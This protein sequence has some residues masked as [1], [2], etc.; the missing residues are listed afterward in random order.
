[1]SAARLLLTLLTLALIGCAAT[2]V[3]KVAE[4]DRYH[5]TVTTADGW[6][7]AL[8][9]VPPAAGTEDR[10][11]HGVPLLMPHGTSVNRFNYMTPGSDLAGYLSS[12]GYDVWVPEHRGDR[13]SRGPTGRDLRSGGWSMDD[14][15]DQDMPAV[16]D[17]VLRITGRERLWWVGHSLGGI[18][19]YIVAQGAYAEQVAG[20]VTIGSPGAYV[21]PSEWVQRVSRHA[22]VLPK[23]GQ[24][25][26]RGAAKALLPVL[27]MAPDSPLLHVVFN[28]ENADPQ[29]LVKFVG[30]GMENIGRG[31]T[32]QYL[33]WLV[34]GPITSLDGSVDYSAGLASITQP[35]LVIAGRVDHI[36][37]AWTARWGYDHLGSADK[38]WQVTGV[39]WGHQADYGHG[40]LVVGR[41]AAE[42]VFPLIG[43]WLDVRVSVPKAEGLLPEEESRLIE[44]ESPPIEEDSA[45][46]LELPSGAPEA[47]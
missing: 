44:G 45:P 5:T 8:F 46:G 33:R 32:E 4:L 37:P 1:M 21:H 36:V 14:I 41:H 2:P 17:E 27:D 18:L 11:G 7:L 39:G 47:P 29:T 13:T 38:T 40:D 9:R 26:T 6:T 19:G 28:L 23:S 35:T 43:A 42:E 30:Q 24:V 15:A 34:Q 22:G 3:R 31:M 20:L 12:L 10:P 16:I 25:P